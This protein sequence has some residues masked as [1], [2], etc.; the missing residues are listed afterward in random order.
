MKFVDVNINVISYNTKL[1]GK[2]EDLDSLRV[3]LGYHQ[4]AF[5]NA[6][7][8]QFTEPKKSIVALHSKF[9]H[10]LRKSQPQIPSQVLIRGE[11]ECLSAYRSVKSNK[12]KIDKPIEKKKLSMR[13]DKRLYSKD[14]NFS[15]NITTAN[16]RKKFNF[17]VYP[18]LKSL[19]EK[20]KH[21]DPLIYE[22]DN[23]DLYISFCFENKVE[24]IKQKL[25]LG[26]D[27][28][29]RRAAAMSDGRIIIDK[30]FNK[31]KR[32]LRYLKRSLQSKN[33][34]SSKRRL[35]K[36]RHKERNKNNN[37]THLIANLIL[38]TSADTIALENLKGIKAKKH[39]YQNKNKISQ[40]P[41]FELRRIL[42]YKAE[43]M[44]KSITLVNPAFT[45]QTDS[46]SGKRDGERK[47][48]RF[49]AKN[50]LV[51]DADLNAAR[52]IGIR[53]KLPVLYGNILDGQAVVNRPIV[54]SVI[55]K[56][57][58]L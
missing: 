54:G 52:N 23:G 7:K 42:S 53:S 51:Y 11:Q 34:K 30:K 40:V 27:L 2:K 10:K 47:G 32:Q 43:N 55:H 57:L 46:Q 18:R 5:N 9:Y 28:G 20:Y 31:E 21:Q 45:S 24:K 13:L 50:G 35:R 15:I 38:K 6:S 37:Q 4:I 16:K 1:L 39:K 26:V 19:L 17:V 3:L 58:S 44:G 12:H 25:C 8:I 22:G 29:V 56:P 36:L 41:L 49:Y 48:C 14:D 33:T